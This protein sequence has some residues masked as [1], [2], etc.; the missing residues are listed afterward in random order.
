MDRTGRSPRRKGRSPYCL[1]PVSKRDGTTRT[2]GL[3]L[4]VRSVRAEARETASG[5]PVVLASSEE[6]AGGVCPEADAGGNR[7]KTETGGNRPRAET[8]ATVR[9]RLPVLAWAS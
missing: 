3:Q 1:T 2:R 9:R 8:V 7:P 6:K 4:S 5:Q